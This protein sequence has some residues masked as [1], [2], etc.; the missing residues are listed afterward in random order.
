MLCRLP[1]ETPGLF[2]SKIDEMILEIMTQLEKDVERTLDE[3]QK[4]LVAIKHLQILMSQ[5]DH[6]A[7]EVPLTDKE[8]FSGLLVSLKGKPLNETESRMVDRIIKN[9]K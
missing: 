1:F 2:L 9:S 8:R 7:E 5:I 4:N 3:E 6:D